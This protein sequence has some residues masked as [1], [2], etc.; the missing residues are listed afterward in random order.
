MGTKNK[1]LSFCLVHS[2]RRA[3]ARGLCQPCYVK[4]L[5]KRNSK[6]AQ[7]QRELANA[8]SAAHLATK[9]KTNVAHYTKLKRE[10]YRRQKRR[11]VAYMG[12]HCMDCRGKFPACCFQ[13]HHRNSQTKKFTIGS[14]AD[15]AAS[16]VRKELKKCDLLCAN[17]HFIRHEREVV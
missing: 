10:R 4:D 12:G 13:F 8:W 17:C 16:S 2:D 14:G 9:R 7:A 11:W 5:K 6:Y 15:R 1:V 3:H